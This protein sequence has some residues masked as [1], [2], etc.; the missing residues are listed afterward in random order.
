MKIKNILTEKCIPV[1]NTC[2]T[3]RDGLFHYIYMQNIKKQIKGCEYI[4]MLFVY[5]AINGIC[6]NSNRFRTFIMLSASYYII[7]PYT[8]LDLQI[9]WLLP[10]NNLV[11]FFVKMTTTHDSHLL[12]QAAALLYDSDPGQHVLPVLGLEQILAVGRGEPQ[13]I[14]ALGVAVGDVDET[15]PDADGQGL[16]EG[17]AVGVGVALLLVLVQAEVVAAQHG[18]HLLPRPHAP[19]AALKGDTAGV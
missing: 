12:V 1:R 16:L 10:V 17:L 2:S 18:V 19:S 9:Y 6:N 7:W 5:N 3:D 14:L 11:Y 4:K 13:H 8:F 15:S